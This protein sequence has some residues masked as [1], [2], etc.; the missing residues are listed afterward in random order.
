[1][2]GSFIGVIKIYMFGEIQYTTNLD[3]RTTLIHY[4]YK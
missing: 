1:M 2:K 4:F 3:S